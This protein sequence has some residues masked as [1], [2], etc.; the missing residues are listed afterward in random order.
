MLNDRQKQF[1][2]HMKELERGEPR[3]KGIYSY[4]EKKF[5]SEKPVKRFKKPFLQIGVELD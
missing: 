3:A 1:R 4:R 2:K 5:T